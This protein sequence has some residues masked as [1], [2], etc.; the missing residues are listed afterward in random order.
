[1]TWLLCALFLEEVI[2]AEGAFPVY[3]ICFSQTKVTWN[4]L[5]RSLNPVDLLFF[6]TSEPVD[7]EVRAQRNKTVF[8][9]LVVDAMVDSDAQLWKSKTRKCASDHSTEY[10]PSLQRL[11]AQQLSDPGSSYLISNRH[12][13]IPF[14]LIRPVAFWTIINFWN[15]K[16]PEQRVPL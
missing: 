7:K 5:Y 11:K 3:K 1:M 4:L 6:P 13:C 9:F 8:S 12:W 16:Y 10:S 14:L 15:V 2:A